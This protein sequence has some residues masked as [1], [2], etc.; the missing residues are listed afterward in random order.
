[1][2]PSAVILLRPHLNLRCDKS[3][4][5]W[6]HHCSPILDHALFWSFT[7]SSR[8]LLKV[9]WHKVTEMTGCL[10]PFLSGV[11]SKRR[12]CPSPDWMKYY[13]SVVCSSLDFSFA[14]SMVYISAIRTTIKEVAKF[15]RNWLNNFGD[16][17]FRRTKWNF[18]FRHFVQR[19]HKIKD[20]L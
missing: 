4:Y 16:E 1:M 5:G 17:T 6:Q 12:L 19:M 3:Q 14:R 15:N 11:L 8:I 10:L 20:D 9:Q 7:A 2:V 18:N 13:R